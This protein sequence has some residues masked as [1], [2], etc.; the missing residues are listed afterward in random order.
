MHKSSCANAQTSIQSGVT[1][2]HLSA[3]VCTEPVPFPRAHTPGH[4]PPGEAPAKLLGLAG[5]LSPQN[6]DGLGSALVSDQAG[7]APVRAQQP[8]PWLRGP[9]PCPAGTWARWELG[10]RSQTT[11]PG[12]THIRVPEAPTHLP[13]APTA[14]GLGTRSPITRVTFHQERPGERGT[15]ARAQAPKHTGLCGS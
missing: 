11:R 15:W 7:R 8:A 12:S 10:Q 9:C 13:T 5:C 4:L 3:Q 6:N 2:S 1:G 14:C